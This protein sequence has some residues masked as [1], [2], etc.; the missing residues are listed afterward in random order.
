MIPRVHDGEHLNSDRIA[1][2]PSAAIW[3]GWWYSTPAACACNLVLATS[4]GLT[5]T[6]EMKA[7][8]AAESARSAIPSSWSARAAGAAGPEEEEGDGE[9]PWCDGA[10]PPERSTREAAA[11]IQVGSEPLEQ[12]T[13]APL[14]GNPSRLDRGG[15]R[16]GGAAAASLS[17]SLSLSKRRRRL[18]E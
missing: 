1:S 15:G 9:E 5:M 3:G 7:A 13:M 6:A 10:A 2:G 14:H 18:L 16:R 17:L 8:P 11:V 4:R 12:P